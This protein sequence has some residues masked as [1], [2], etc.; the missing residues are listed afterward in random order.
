MLFRIKLS[1]DELERLV[2]GKER[3]LHRCLDAT[4]T[5]AGFVAHDVWLVYGVSNVP[6]ILNHGS[7]ESFPD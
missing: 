1:D 6:V 2:N 5:S 7:Q 3:Q 4:W